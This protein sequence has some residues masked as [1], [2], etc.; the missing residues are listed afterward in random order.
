MLRLA[1]WEEL[2]PAEIAA[3]LGCS[4]NAAA[5]RLHRARQRLAGE[6]APGGPAMNHDP[7][8]TLRSRNP[9]PRESLPEAP[10]A[11]ASRIA[12]GHPSLRRGLAI[13]TA[14]AAVV[15]VAGGGW[16]IWSRTGGRQTVVG[17]TTTTTTTTTHPPPRTRSR[18]VVVYFL[19]DGALIPVARDLSVLN[20][21]PARPR[22]AHGGTAPLR[23]RAAWDACVR[24]PTRS[25]PR[26]N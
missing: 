2:Q 16:L 10:M 9:A 15:L 8:D 26:P 25:T 23:A 13:A 17:P 21:L 7:F 12:A 14:A 20:V 1:A 24:C 4:A 6:I 22:A 3:V 5:V 19:K 18:N 11:L